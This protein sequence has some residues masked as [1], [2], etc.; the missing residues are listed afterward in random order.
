MATILVVQAIERIAWTGLTPQLPELARTLGASEG[1]AAF[2]LS[3]FVFLTY[4][5]AYPLAPVVDRYLRPG[6]G[7]GVGL[8]LLAAG[9]GLLG[10]GWILTAALL[11]PIGL[12]LFRLSIGIAV[13]GLDSTQQPAWWLIY[14]AANIGGVIGGWSA[15]HIAWTWGLPAVCYVCAMVTLSGSILCGFIRSARPTPAEER[16]PSSQC[17]DGARWWAV[18]CICLLSVGAWIAAL[19]PTTTMV[20]FAKRMSPW[21]GPFQLGVGT[22]SALH[23]AQVIVVVLAALT[24][25]R[26]ATSVLSSVW[27]LL[28]TAAGFAVLASAALDAGPRSPLWL[29]SAYALLAIAEPFL[30]VAGV[31]SVARIAPEGYEGRAIGAWYG[32]I[33]VG[34]LGASLLGLSWDRMS[35]SVYFG[36]L[37]MALILNAA[38]MVLVASRLDALLRRF[39]R[40]VSPRAESMTQPPPPNERKD[41]MIP[42]LAT[43]SQSPPAESLLPAVQPSRWGMILAGLPILLPLPLVFM[44]G[45]PLPVRAWSAIFCGLAVLL[46]GSHL[47]ARLMLHLGQ[48]APSFQ[49]QR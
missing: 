29:L 16:A 24:L 35:P 25:R 23:S 3:L 15:Q 14:L 46:S 38:L 39:A 28:S 7:C 8:V 17:M 13:A 32:S 21:L 26:T 49:G 10:A 34:M 18:R 19:Q 45:L 30:F 44:Q 41:A 40:Q 36:L 43:P 1:G 37:A 47:F 27:A 22:Y 4:I 48:P 12:A 9:Y 42:A 11:L 2:W 5:T 6:S 20:L 33:G 31:G